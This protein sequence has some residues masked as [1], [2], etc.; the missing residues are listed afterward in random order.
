MEKKTE[1]SSHAH[2]IITD[3]AYIQNL[4]IYTMIY[5]Y[6]CCTVTIGMTHIHFCSVEIFQKAVSRPMFAPSIH[7]NI[8]QMRKQVHIQTHN[9]FTIFPFKHTRNKR[10]PSRNYYRTIDE[11]IR[12][13]GRANER[14]N[15][16]NSRRKKRIF[17]Y[18]K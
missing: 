18:K 9:T 7:E 16:T 3:N 11:G 8:T 6:T 17:P 2:R 1:E 12:M 15:E 10:I 14:M 4:Y 5:Q 13:N